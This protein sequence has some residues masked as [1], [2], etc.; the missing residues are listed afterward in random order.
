[1]YTKQKINLISDK[2]SATKQIIGS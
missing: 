1:M 2:A